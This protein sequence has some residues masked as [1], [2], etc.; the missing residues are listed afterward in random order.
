[1][2][3]DDLKETYMETSVFVGGNHGFRNFSLKVK[4]NH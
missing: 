2:K 4:L 3:M 1:M